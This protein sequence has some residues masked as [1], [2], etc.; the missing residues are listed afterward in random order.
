MRVRRLIWYLLEIKVEEWH[1]AGVAT[2]CLNGP[3]VRHEVILMEKFGALSW[4]RYQPL[5]LID[6]THDYVAYICVELF[7]SHLQILIIL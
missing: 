1:S 5:R 3:L 2:C 7:S 6:M 4:L